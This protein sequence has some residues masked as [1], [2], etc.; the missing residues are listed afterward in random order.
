MGSYDQDA[1]GSIE[2][3]R[4]DVIG[5]N[6]HADDGGRV[7]C[8]GGRRNGMLAGCHWHSM[9]WCPHYPGVGHQ[10]LGTRDK[11]SGIRIGTLPVTLGYD[12]NVHNRMI[13]EH[14]IFV[15]PHT[16]RVATP[17]CSAPLAAGALAEAVPRSG[18]VTGTLAQ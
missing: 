13:I 10:E 2:G 14:R 9:T 18:C 6:D 5:T 8:G 12:P 11:E 4:R 16:P 15:P 17:G 1:E 3:S 7:D